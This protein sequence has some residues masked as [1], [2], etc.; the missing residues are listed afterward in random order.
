MNK[1][2]TI[3]RIKSIKE[4]PNADKLELAQVLGWTVVVKKGEF[5][6]GDLCV[7][8]ALDSILPEREEFEFLRSKNFR[9]RTCKLRG[10]ISQGI[11]FPLAVAHKY[12]S[13]YFKDRHWA[14]RWHIEKE[15]ASL[16]DFIKVRLHDSYFTEGTDITEYLSVAKYEKPVPQTQ[17]AKG[18][19]PT[20]L[21]SKTDEER[22]QNIPEI[23]DRLYGREVYVSKK[24]DGTSA[25]Y[26]TDPAEGLLVCSRN[27]EIKCGDN[28]YWE[29]VD[30]Y[31]LHRLPA[32]TAVQGE[33][34]GPGIQ[35]NPEGL[36]EVELK[37]FNVYREGKLLNYSDFLSFC[38]VY[39]L[40]PVDLV[41][42]GPLRWDSLENWLDFANTVRYNNG[43]QAEGIVVRL[44]ENQYCE[45]LGKPLSFKV[46]SSAYELK[47]E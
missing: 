46:I 8:V 23:L 42:R 14:G 30:K 31:R 29:M 11:C 38:M 10:V 28:V 15:I 44:I 45:E 36:K 21:V 13:Q 9:V 12:V 43:K 3:Q 20:H 6:E 33:I 41:W 37:V 40:T 47:E 39:G 35:K 1:L 26:I 18:N 32:G 34:V 22:I 25:T 24:H 2:A 4:H 27:L 19:F 7:Y 17:E 5:Q 16:E